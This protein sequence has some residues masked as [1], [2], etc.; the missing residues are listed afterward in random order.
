MKTKSICS[1]FFAV[2][3]VFLTAATALPFATLAQ[4]DGQ[5]KTTATRPNSESAQPA[6]EKK[7]VR[8]TAAITIQN[9]FKW[10]FST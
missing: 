2:I 7:K 6:A 4:E 3:A 9:Y 5:L 8:G 10:R 1:A